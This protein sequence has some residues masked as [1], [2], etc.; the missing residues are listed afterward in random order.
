MPLKD[1]AARKAWWA[2]Y[3]KEHNEELSEK[4]KKYYKDN[5]ER[6]RALSQK[7]SR[8]PRGRFSHLRASA[9]TRNIAV[10]LSF[11]EF[12]SLIKDGV[13]TYCKETLS[14]SGGALDRKNSILG[15]SQ[16]NCV[17]CCKVCNR[18]RGKDDISYDEMFE[19]VKLLKRLRRKKNA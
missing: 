13:C 8:T 17:P 19:V 18:M 5:R 16:E 1:I 9:R 15:Y 10:E 4:G 12:Y 7:N 3:S 11:E 14:P 2:I 6:V